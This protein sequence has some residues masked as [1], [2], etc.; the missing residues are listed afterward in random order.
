MAR[1]LIPVMP[2]RYN[3]NPVGSSTA[4]VIMKANNPFEAPVRQVSRR[5][6][7]LPG[8]GAIDVNALQSS[9]Q[10]TL[11]ASATR[12]GFNWGEVGTNLAQTGI[13]IL[14]TAG[15][16]IVNKLVPPP[17]TTLTAPSAVMI[18]GQPNQGAP[19]VPYYQQAPAPSKLPWILGG[20]AVLG[21]VLFLT[22]RKPSRR[23]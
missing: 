23:K 10:E 3:H 18:P 15:Q 19:A 5:S 4:T 2:R 8:M 14:G 1:V 21:G 11:Q 9:A 16:N 12:S 17:T 6:G 22:M 20:V 7:S 13:S